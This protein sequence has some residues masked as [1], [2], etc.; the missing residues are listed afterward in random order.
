MVDDE[1]EDFSRGKLCFG[2]RDTSRHITSTKYTPSACP[3]TNTG[4]KILLIAASVQLHGHADVLRHSQDK[5]YAFYHI[6]ISHEACL[7]LSQG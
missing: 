1:E 7:V 5:F 4:H 3:E 2:R 6:Y